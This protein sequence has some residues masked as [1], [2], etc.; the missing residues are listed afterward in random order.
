M[1]VEFPTTGI[2]VSGLLREVL[3]HSQRL[4]VETV[5]VFFG[6]FITQTDGHVLEHG[7]HHAQVTVL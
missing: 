4:S 3:S 7:M 1:M 6:E 5:C 2:Q